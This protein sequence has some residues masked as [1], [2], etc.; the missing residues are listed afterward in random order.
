LVFVFVLSEAIMRCTTRHAGFTLIELL[1]VIAIIAVLIG[2][3]LPAI[4]KV[5]EAANRASCQSKLRQLGIALH[6][7]H[8]TQKVFPNGG[9]I[10]SI[11][12][13][14]EQQ[15]NLSGRT[16]LTMINCP[17]DP[18]GLVTSPDGQGLT[19]YLAV[20]GLRRDDKAGVMYSGSKTRISDI[21]DGTSTTVMIGERPPTP[22][23]YVSIWNSI[24]YLLGIELG[25]A[26]RTYVIDP[27]DPNSPYNRCP[28]TGTFYF[29]PGEITNHCAVLHFWSPH[30]GGGNFLFADGSTRLLS[31]NIGT[32]TLLQL[33]TRSG[34]EVVDQGSY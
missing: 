19:N 1:V 14:I 30:P 7:Y 2:L 26:N 25:V 6:S 8:D 24:G 3:L 34:G 33:A 16:K 9:W 20:S 17:S 32:T 29:S 5:R 13:Y 21:T 10:R 28:R 18:R 27:S 4:Q 12:P 11:L 23:L 22:D 15:E 31:Y